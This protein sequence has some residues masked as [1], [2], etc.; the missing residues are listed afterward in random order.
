MNMKHDKIIDLL[1]E[2]RR[3]PPV[4]LEDPTFLEIARFPH[5]ELVWSNLL[6]FFFDPDGPHK[7][8]FLFLEALLHE[9]QF[10]NPLPNVEVKREVETSSGNFIDLLIWSDTHLICIE[11]KGLSGVDNPL[12]D[13]ANYVTQ[14]ARDRNIRQF[15]LGLRAH[16]P[17]YGFVPLTYASFFGRIRSLFDKYRT[18]ANNHYK[19][20]LLD[21]MDTIDRLQSGASNMTPEYLAL[22]RERE[23]DITAFLGTVKKYQSEL[24]GMVERLGSL[25]EV[26]PY[27]NVMQKL[28]NESHGL[29][30]VLVHDIKMPNLPVIG[31]DAVISAK[32]WTIEIFFRPSGKHPVGRLEDLLKQL[33]I[34]YERQDGQYRLAYPVRFTYNDPVDKIQ[35]H[36]QPLVEKIASAGSPNPTSRKALVAIH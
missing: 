2:F 6:A 18:D 36:L 8:G 23:P 20:L 21:F 12:S 24:K 13:Y 17:A 15:L 28:W 1:A 14:N 25:V 34:A 16:G 31:I 19:I 11:N 26:E 3:L 35:A 22:F 10:F 32:G 4:A 5:Y 29:E 33:N 7:F 30:Y 27:K 9:E